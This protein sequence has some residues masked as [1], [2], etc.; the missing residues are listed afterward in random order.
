MKKVFTPDDI[1]VSLISAMGY[2]F[3]YAIPEAL[4]LHTV[5]CFG[6]CFAVG[7]ALEEVADKI[8]F[9]RKVQQNKT[10]RY[11][12]FGCITLLFIACYIILERYFA[13]SLWEDLDEELF[14]SV[15]LPVA[16]F[17]LSMGLKAFKKRKLVKKYGTG[18]AGFRFDENIEKKWNAV[19]GSNAE[20]STYEGK[21]PSVKTFSGIYI[22]KKSKEGVRFLGIPYA[23]AERWKKPVP[24]QSSETIREAFYFGNSEIQ[25]KGSHN[26][27]NRFDQGEDCLNLN[28]WTEKLEPEAKKPVLVYFHGGDGRYGGSANPMYHLANL[29][30]SVPDGVFVSIN[31]RFGV[32]GV[33]DFSSTGFPD[34]GEYTDSTA[35][36]LLDQLEALKWIKANIAAFGGDPEN[37][38]VAGDSYGGACI[39]L[40]VTMEQAKG[41]FQRAMILCASTWDAPG[42][43]EIASTLGKQLAEE[44][45]AGSVADLQALTP[46]Q[47][48]DFSNRNYGLLALPPRD[49]LL[50]PQDTDRAYLEGAS[51]D[52]EFIFGIA[53]DDVSAWQAMVAGEVSLDDQAAAA[54]E[55][56][57]EFV[58]ADRVTEAEALLRKYSESGTSVAAAKMALM[59]D[60]QF[61]ACPLHNCRVLS[62]AGCKVRCFHWDVQGDIEKLTA[63]AASLVTALLGN[64]EIAEQM[65]YLHDK[66][67]T[68][69]MQ[70]FVSKFMHGQSLEFSNNELRGVSQIV[71]NEFDPE[72]EYVLNVQ[73]E[74]I[75]MMESIFSGNIRALE[76]AVFEK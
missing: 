51:S 13:Y 7:M 8:I 44:F 46:E 19:L 3:G 39:G 30:K 42:G 75:Q 41:L 63:N 26:I 21:E 55:S 73:K 74:N 35:L 49:G 25:P 31:Y 69:I 6:L 12:V 60:L 64:T 28:I 56:L 29:A 68:E 1:M 50:I 17:L 58:G 48:R 62:Q 72:R 14:Y 10:R 61:K 43:N 76:R 16:G 11:L 54:Y 37:I 45:H 20:L 9:N 47:L 65:G 66:S 15:T 5:L 52:V 40:L 27:L 70:A 36:S 53:R 18:E 24:A 2:G 67:T 22:G 38:T 33:V 59:A 57:L 34:A 32:F 4:G 23:S 71:W